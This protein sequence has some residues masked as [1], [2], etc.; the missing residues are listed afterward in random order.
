MSEEPSMDEIVAQQKMQCPFCKIVAGQIPSTK[1]YED[2]I[3]LA[4]MDINPAVTGHVLLLPKEHHP[5]LQIVPRPTFEHMFKIA[6][7]ILRAIEE[8]MMVQKSSIFIAGGA[9]AGQQSAHFMMH[10]LPRESG[11]KLDW[12]DAIGM[13]TQTDMVTKQ[14]FTNNIVSGIQQLSAHA[15]VATFINKNPLPPMPQEPQEPEPTEAQKQQISKL[16]ESNAE[17]KEAIL[18]H[19]DDVKVMVN[20]DPKWAALFRGINIDALSQQLRKVE[21]SK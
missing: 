16:Y 20:K 7:Y 21:D 12:L 10:L 6:K 3:V 14:M 18:Y 5:F 2:D 4:I 1:V 11:D 15:S 13:N 8:A 17:F 19:P 9:V